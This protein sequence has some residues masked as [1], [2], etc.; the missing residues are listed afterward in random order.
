MVEGKLFLQIRSIN[1]V[2]PLME[3][4]IALPVTK[5]IKIVMGIQ[6]CLI[7]WLNFD[8]KENGRKKAFPTNSKHQCRV[9]QYGEHD[10]CANNNKNGD[11]YV[12][13]SLSHFTDE[14]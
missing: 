13:P 6:V 1:I 8:Y 4:T 7:S 2:Y 12:H 10:C 11:Y 9:S 5:R 14:L 3:K